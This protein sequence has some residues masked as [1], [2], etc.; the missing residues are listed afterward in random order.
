MVHC[1]PRLPPTFFLGLLLAAMDAP[2]GQPT[3]DRINVRCAWTRRLAEAVFM[4]AVLGYPDTR[5]NE[6]PLDYLMNLLEFAC[7]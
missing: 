5:C 7:E 1:T 2:D 3:H 4:A 6:P